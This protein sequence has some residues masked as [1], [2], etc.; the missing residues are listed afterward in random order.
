M[1]VPPP[2]E[3]HLFWQRCQ[4]MTHGLCLFLSYTDTDPMKRLFSDGHQ[5]LEEMH[6]SLV[7]SYDGSRTN[8][9]VVTAIA[10]EARERSQ[11]LG[12]RGWPGRLLAESN[13]MVCGIDSHFAVGLATNNHRR[14]QTAKLALAISLSVHRQVWFRNHDTA[15]LCVMCAQ[16]SFRFRLER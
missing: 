16:D 6:P 9:E 13:F 1:A 3:P 2:F 11:G 15:N 5:L 7:V 10:N 14:V 12:L 8:Q 4:S